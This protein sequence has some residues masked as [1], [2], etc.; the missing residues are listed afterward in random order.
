MIR[1]IKILD[2]QSLFDVALQAAG[3]IEAA[4]I[5]AVE[6][7]VSISSEVAGMELQTVITPI[8]TI[9]TKQYTVHGVIPATDITAKNSEDIPYGGINFM[10]IEIDFIIN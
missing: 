8:D 10:G 3:S 5:I 2:R 9:V 1:K 4:I 7:N 6:N